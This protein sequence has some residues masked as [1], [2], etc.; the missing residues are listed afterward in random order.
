M[1][2]ANFEESVANATIMRLTRELA[3]I[4]EVLAA[5]KADQLRSPS[6]DYFVDRQAPHCG[7]CAG[8]CCRRWP[9][10]MR[11]MLARIIYKYQWVIMVGFSGD[12]VCSWFRRG[13]VIIALL[14]QAV[15]QQF[16]QFLIWP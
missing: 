10:F 15:L 5:A 16:V 9:D 11:C 13:S 1:D 14:I 6:S 8:V 7:A 3:F 4:D 2:D 12:S